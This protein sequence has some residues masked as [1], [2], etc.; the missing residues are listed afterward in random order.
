M[1]EADYL[2]EVRR[3]AHQ[4]YQFMEK[5]MFAESAGCALWYYV[6]SLLACGELDT[7]LL[8]RHRVL[9]NPGKPAL[10][11]VHFISFL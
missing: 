11:L 8:Q 10:G 4:Q 3:T 9:P 7:I 1:Q 6:G 5:C 2:L